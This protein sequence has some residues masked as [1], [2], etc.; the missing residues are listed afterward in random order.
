MTWYH[1]AFS[2]SH[3]SAGAILSQKMSHSRPEKV[4]QTQ[5]FQ[6]VA[7]LGLCHIPC[8]I[9]PAIMP[10]SPSRR[11][12]SLIPPPSNTHIPWFCSA[13]TPAPVRSGSSSRHKR[14]IMLVKQRGDVLFRGPGSADTHRGDP[15]AF[16]C[17]EPAQRDD[18]CK[19]DVPMDSLAPPACLGAAD[20]SC[21]SYYSTTRGA[22]FLSSGL[23]GIVQLPPVT[24][25][26]RHSHGNRTPDTAAN[27]QR[28]LAASSL[29]QSASPLG[30]ISFHSVAPSSSAP[31]TH[32]HRVMG[33]SRRTRVDTSTATRG[34]M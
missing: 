8:H 26:S 32:C 16:G 28:Q 12:A 23:L 27:R 5:I 33:A 6:Q 14:R 29:C 31:P 19:V 2:A 10:L 34:S 1:P 24:Y 17:P 20:A 18:F 9:A 15:G 11:G 13:R 7:A 4:P 22:F 3:L 25:I 30:A 21:H